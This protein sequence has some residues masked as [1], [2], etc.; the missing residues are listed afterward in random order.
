MV[1]HNPDEFQKITPKRKKWR[2]PQN[3]LIQNA[4]GWVEM[5]KD[6]GWRENER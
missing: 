2:A 5:L 1:P 4:F 6:G 3:Q